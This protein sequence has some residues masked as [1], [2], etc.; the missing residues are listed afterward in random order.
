MLTFTK[1]GVFTRVSGPY[2]EK[3][4]LDSSLTFVVPGREYDYAFKTGE[5]D[6]KIHLY[7]MEDSKFLVGITAEAV[8]RMNGEV[9]V[10]VVEEEI[11]HVEFPEITPDFIT[12]R[13]NNLRQYQQSAIRKALYAGGGIVQIPTGGGKT[14]VASGILKAFNKKSLFLVNSIRLLRQTCSAFR[15]AGLVDVGMIGDDEFSPGKIT[16]ATVQT[17]SKRIRH[18]EVQELLRSIEV[19]ILDE[20]HHCQA[21]SFSSLVVSIPAKWRYGLSG[22]PFKTSELSRYEDWLVLG[23]CGDICYMLPSSYL[24]DLGYLARPIIFMLDVDAPKLHIYSQN[25]WAKIYKAGIVQ[26]VERNKMG[27]DAVR[28]MVGR[29]LRTLVLAQQIEH[30][31]NLVRDIGYQ[32]IQVR[33]LLGDDRVVVYDPE[34]QEVIEEKD[35]VIDGVSAVSE[36]FRRGEFQ[37]LV[38]S[39]VLDEGIDIPEVEALVILSGGKSYIKTIQRLGRGLR[40]KKGGVNT[41]YVIDFLDNHHPLLKSHSIKRREKYLAEEHE[42]LGYMDYIKELGCE[43]HVIRNRSTSHTASSGLQELQPISLLRM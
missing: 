17:L 3:K 13:G 8:R 7:D 30:V 29:G 9:E 16:V 38:A 24:V 36:Q 39:T 43:D 32:G 20:T 35:E 5:W 2:E 12:V 18:P 4:Y 42:V 6:G 10:L 25:A 23:L 15:E 19:L 27:V 34:T 1:D 21:N 11:P 40:P 37:V 14:V 28:K 33:G 22:T 41:V 31:K 26:S